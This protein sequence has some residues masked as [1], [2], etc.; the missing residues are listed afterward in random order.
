MIKNT[1]KHLLISLLFSSTSL[2]SASIIKEKP[3]TLVITSYNNS[4][5]V[6][7][8]LD[9]AFNQKYDNYKIIYYDDASEDNTSDIAENY[10]SQKIILNKFKIIKSNSRVRKLK[11]IYNIYHG[12]D[13][14]NIIIQLDGDDW[15]AHENVLYE[16][17]KY[18]SEN[19]IWLT[20]GSFAFADGE[21]HFG[22]FPPKEIIKKGDFRKWKWA[23]FPPRTFYAWLF[24]QIKLEEL[25]T[26]T[27]PKFEGKFYPI[28]NDRAIF[29]PMLEM[30][31][32]NFMFTTK[33]DYIYNPTPISNINN[34]T[35]VNIYAELSKIISS[36]HNSKP[37]QHK[38]LNKPIYT[39]INNKDYNTDLIIFDKKLT[40]NIKINLK[41]IDGI[42]NIL[43][44]SNNRKKIFKI[45]KDIININTKENLSHI[46]LNYLISSKS[47]FVCLG[48]NNFEILDMI[49][50]KYCSKMLDKTFA[51]A[52]YL[53][54]DYF[55]DP[56]FKEKNVNSIPCENIDFEDLYAWKFN[57]SHN[58]WDNFNNF[59]FTIYR[60]K[61]II[62]F[63]K[64]N[65][66]DHIE[67][68]EKKWKTSKV[69]LNQVGL[70]FKNK[71]IINI[72]KDK[73][74]S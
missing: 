72:L 16:I 9:S 36:E 23:F 42:N 14:D 19:N 68:F 20:Y 48:N 38:S 54:L 17:N 45:N 7:K 50:L 46:I 18:Y 25:L 30:A 51:Y 69:N 63:L 65:I 49:D 22:Q 61:E 67:D 10:A 1:F 13:D 60:K 2:F 34:Q 62:D 33:I 32:K 53:N 28:A 73:K 24:K 29:F 11:A 3:I 31:R 6:K 55:N 21:K 12:I 35:T 4:T 59:K 43:L 66:I 58:T 57:L 8:N 52:F 47:E 70:F 27:A 39:N 15:F 71:K 64:S 41:K 40:E 44:I 26:N 74:C 56:F 5:W 37:I